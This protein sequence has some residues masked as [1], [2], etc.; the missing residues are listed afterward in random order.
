M[1][2]IDGRHGGLAKINRS[3]FLPPW[4]TAQVQRKVRPSNAARAKE[5]VACDAKIT[6]YIT[7]DGLRWVWM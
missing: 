4:F 6:K 2:H 5:T 7:Q 1:E 3:M